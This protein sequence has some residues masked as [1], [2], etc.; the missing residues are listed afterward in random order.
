MITMGRLCP[1]IT[2]SSSPEETEKRIGS[3]ILSGIPII[4]LDNC[5][6]DLGGELM[7]QLS[8]RPVIKIRILGRSETPDC[9]SHTAVFATGNNITFRDD[10]D[11]RGVMC[12]LEALDERPELREFQK[13]AVVIAAADRG[14]YVAAV[15]TIIRA[16]I[17][18]G[19]PKVCGPFN[20][21]AQWTGMVRAP[22]VWLGE[23]DPVVSTETIRDEDPVLSS[24]RGMIEFWINYELGLATPLTTS[25]IIDT[26]CAQQGGGDFNPPAFKQL[27]LQV[28]SNER[29]PREV[30]PKRLTLW[31]G[32]ISGRVVS[33][34]SPE[35]AAGKY[36]LIRSQR[37]AATVQ[38]HLE[39]MD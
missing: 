16:Y 24:I 1:V 17:T 11:R 27:L 15:L 23:T 25:S 21:Y 7:C 38:F 32:R 5:T 35:T 33:I 29:D 2:T 36:R 28:A 12:N 20:S 26:A 39:R 31:L 14:K 30:S 4:S 19:S 6:H 10:M 9:E 22:L 37:N 13:D 3:V 8:E 34:K 18:A